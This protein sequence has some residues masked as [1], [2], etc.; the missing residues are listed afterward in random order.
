LLIAAQLHYPLSQNGKTIG[1]TN[2]TK[3]NQRKNRISLAQKMQPR[4]HPSTNANSPLNSCL[5]KIYHLP[6]MEQ[7]RS[8]QVRMP[9]D[10]GPSAR[11]QDE[12]CTILFV[13]E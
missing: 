10:I 9:L 1:T 5:N 13:Q 12:E 6:V 4:T 7:Y 11:M 2:K 8:L 3:F